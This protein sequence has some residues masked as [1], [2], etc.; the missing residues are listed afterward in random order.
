MN[1][2]KKWAALLIGAAFLFALMHRSC[3]GCQQRAAKIRSALG[4]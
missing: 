2:R 4:L 3:G 1:N